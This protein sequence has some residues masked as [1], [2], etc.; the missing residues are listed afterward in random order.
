MTNKTLSLHISLP[1]PAIRAY[2]QK[3]DIREF[4]LFGSVLRD[5]FTP[6]S[7]IDVLVTFEDNVCYTLFDL[8]YMAD[9]LE[10]ILGRKVD[11]IDRLAIENSPNPIRRNE[12][13][14]TAQVIYAA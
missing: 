9:E 14:S 11:F 13:L 4:A 2:C 12:I 7:D 10:T 1:M 6:T 8:V 3:W 5:D